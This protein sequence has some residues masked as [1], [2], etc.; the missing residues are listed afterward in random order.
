MKDPDGAAWSIC[1]GGHLQA[2]RNTLPST[3]AELLQSSASRESSAGILC[4]SAYG[5]EEFHAYS[6][7]VAE[8]RRTLAGLREHGLQ[9]GDETLDSFA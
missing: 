1:H 3:L 7:L 9:P 4:L 5:S 8:G 6:E 2:D